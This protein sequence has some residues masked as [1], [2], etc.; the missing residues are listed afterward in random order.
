MT[1]EEKE[2]LDIL[3]Q[4]KSLSLIELRATKNSFQVIIENTKTNTKTL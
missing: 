1:N 2:T 4:K 3:S